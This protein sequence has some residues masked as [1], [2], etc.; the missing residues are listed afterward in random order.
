MSESKREFQFDALI[1]AIR[2]YD[3][4]D[5]EVKSTAHTSAVTVRWHAIEGVL[6]ESAERDPAPTE[7]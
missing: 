7:R 4:E 3:L 2:E 6:T 5:A 1:D